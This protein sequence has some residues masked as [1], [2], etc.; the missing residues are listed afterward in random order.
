MSNSIHCDCSMPPGGCRYPDC[1]T[2]AS[3]TVLQ[4]QGVVN[5]VLQ[6]LKA[7]VTPKID[8]TCDHIWD[9]IEDPQQCVTCGLSFMRYVHSSCP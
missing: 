1:Q 4:Q 2:F 7:H 3:P 6:R 9:R 8:E 5:P